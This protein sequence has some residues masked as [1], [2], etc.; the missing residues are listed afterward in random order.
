MS[1]GGGASSFCWGEFG[2]MANIMII[3]LSLFVDKLGMG[4]TSTD[5][6]VVESAIEFPDLFPFL[7]SSD[8][9]FDGLQ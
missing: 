6:S 1:F 7:N 3:C 9:S 4:R 2:S 8:L 5:L